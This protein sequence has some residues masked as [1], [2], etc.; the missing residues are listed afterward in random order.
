M[1][2]E[3]R[4]RVDLDLFIQATFPFAQMVR[5]LT[6][7]LFIFRHL[8]VFVIGRLFQR[9]K[10]RYKLEIYIIASEKVLARAESNV[11]LH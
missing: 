8:V 7:E 6:T 5:D 2:E 4:S 3:L 11:G 1:V 10:V 9:L